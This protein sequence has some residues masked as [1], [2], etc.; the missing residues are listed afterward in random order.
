MHRRSRTP[1]HAAVQLCAASAALAQSDV[2]PLHK[3]S[4]GEN[5]G[6]MNWRDAGEPAASQGARLSASFLSGHVWCEN[7]GWLNLGDGTPADGSSYGNTDGADFGVNLEPRTGQLS[8]LAW[9]ENIGWV[10]FSGGALADPARP[11]RLDPT[12]YRLRGFVWAENVGWINLDDGEHFV[13]FLCPADFN[14]DGNVDTRDVLAFLNAWNRQ[15]RASDC[16]KNRVIDTRDVL[17]YLNLW[18]SGC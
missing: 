15:D 4:W 16:D 3:L 12:T 1:I 17:C 13:A 7:V 6:W 10:N 5:I 8:G 18:N 9:G 14:G 2:D 11:A